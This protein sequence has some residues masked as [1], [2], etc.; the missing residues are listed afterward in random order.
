[1][2]RMTKPLR[3]LSVAEDTTI[4]SRLHSNLTSTSK[5][6]SVHAHLRLQHVDSLGRE[7]AQVTAMR[8]QEES[9]L[10]PA[11]FRPGDVLLRDL[12]L[13]YGNFAYTGKVYSSQRDPSPGP[14]QPG[15][16]AR[17]LAKPTLPP[18]GLGTAWL[19]RPCGELEGDPGRLG[20]PLV[21]AN[22][23]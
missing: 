21:P 8:W 15:S 12:D 17:A 19:E 14:K 5:Q 22:G 20:V 2:N 1:M 6:L 11:R 18:H 13:L 7:H 10:P 3:Q 4:T 23:R 16:A 9:L